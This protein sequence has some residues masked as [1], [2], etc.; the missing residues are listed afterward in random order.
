VYSFLR[1][2]VE[3]IF[4]NKIKNVVVVSIMYIVV[5]FCGSIDHINGSN[6]EATNTDDLDNALQQ[7]RGIDGVA[8]VAPNRPVGR[9]R[10]L[11]VGRRGRNHANAGRRVGE[12]PQRAP[13]IA[14]EAE[15]QEPQQEVPQVDPVFE[16]RENLRLKTARGDID[17]TP[18]R[19]ILC[20]LS[21]HYDPGDPRTH[22]AYDGTDFCVYDV[23]SNTFVSTVGTVY[24]A[25]PE[26]TPLA[27]VVQHG[28]GYAVMSSIPNAGKN[29]I[30]QSSIGSYEFSDSRI[31]GRYFS[32]VENGFY[33]I[34]M[35]MYFAK[36][37]PH[38]RAT[39]PLHESVV[40]SATKYYPNVPSEVVD[41]TVNYFLRVSLERGLRRNGMR[42]V[43]IMTSGVTE[44]IS[45]LGLSD[46]M[47]NSP[48]TGLLL[49]HKKPWITTA[50]ECQLPEIWEFDMDRVANVVA[51]N[52]ALNANQFR[53]NTQ[54]M[55]RAEWKVTKFFALIGIG[56]FF[57][58]YANST[59]N[60]QKAFKRIL[61]KR[62]NDNVERQL[63]QNQL[64]LSSYFHSWRKQRIDCLN[65]CYFNLFSTVKN[66]DYARLMR[67]LEDLEDMCPRLLDIPVLGDDGSLSTLYVCNDSVD[68]CTFENFMCKQSEKLVSRCS[69]SK[70]DKKLVENN[71][72]DWA[73]YSLYL[74]FYENLYPGDHRH[75]AAQIKHI[76]KKLRQSYVDGVLLHEDTDVMV[77]RMEC[78]IKNELAK[79]GKVPRFFV[80]YNEGCMYSNYLPE[81]VK[82]CVDGSHFASIS[83]VD[84]EVYIMAK[85]RDG[86]LDSLFNMMISHRSTN[87]KIFVAVYSDDSVYSG[88]VNGT[89]F[90]FNVDIS[91]C[92]ASNRELVFG[93]THALMCKFCVSEATGL[94]QQ[95][96]KPLEIVN[97]ADA[98]EK[99]KLSLLHPFEGSGSVLTTILNHTAS[100][101]IAMSFLY[102]IALNYTDI[103]SEEHVSQILVESAGMTG[104][105]VT[106]ETIVQDGDVT[107]ELIQFLKHSPI[108]GTDGL[109]HSCINM[110]C[111]LRSL[112]SVD[113]TM[114]AEMLGWDQLR[115][116]MSTYSERMDTFVSNVVMGYKHEPSN[117]ILTALRNRFN[118][119]TTSV[120]QSDKSAVRTI[121]VMRETFAHWTCDEESFKRRYS[122]SNAE[123]EELINQIAHIQVGQIYSSEAISKI[124]KQDYGLTANPI[125]PVQQLHDIFV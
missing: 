82:I 51:Q 105:L 40:A 19:E 96:C 77:R 22:W 1:I 27:G 89:P 14:N 26:L 121:G 10:G 123:L 78:K 52:C 49:D 33:L 97:P 35:Y 20:V 110:G 56:S 75:A 106:T 38:S 6:G 103:N 98:G 57:I 8:N 7:V 48:I 88:C 107:F 11:N 21:Q 104:H 94:V 4:K 41:E 95:C 91:S 99:L 85:P 25:I 53:F 54:G 117:P 90:T 37:F 34:P 47:T 31:G 65:P 102:N 44:E 64:H 43:A 69:R 61:G 118:S 72:L 115:F 125:V 23:N 15:A 74:S 66:Q 108:L 92:D 9:V 30:A 5:V 79:V 116:N 58:Q 84:I 46:L 119:H 62:E 71:I 112:G 16:H 67:E 76:K 101:L 29:I 24:R 18:Q 81:F 113:G 59:N 3:K 83:G 124:Y 42:D 13:N 111:L 73:Y 32:L 109:Y 120:I 39:K 60:S 50:V 93:L 87:D 55:G 2:C 17:H 122:L 86:V 80:S 28:Y 114:H 68:N 12:R 45:Y 70:I 100:Y 63:D 36:A